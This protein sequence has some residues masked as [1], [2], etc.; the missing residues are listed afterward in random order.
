MRRFL[1]FFLLLPFPLLA[2][3]PAAAPQAKPQTEKPETVAPAP[4]LTLAEA[5]RIGLENNY[6]IRLV[7]QDER[8]AE[9]N[10]TRGNAGQL[11]VVN[12]NLTRNFNRNNINQRFGTTDASGNPTAPRIVN[13]GTS[14]LLNTNVAA[15][16]TIFDGFG[17]FIA[18][19]RLR[20]VA[21]SQEQFT[22]ATAEETV[23]DITDAY[24]TVVRE[25]G[26]IRSFEEALRIGQQRIDLTQ[27]R[28]DVGVGAKVE[29]LTARVDYNA[30]RSALI[31][32]Q[33]AL[34]T[35]KVNLN[36]LL[37]RAPSVDFLPADS[38]VVSR[39]LNRE[40]VTQ[41][42]RQNNPRLQQARIN[43][44]VATY[45]RR[46]VRASHFPQVGLTTGYGFNRNINNAAFAGTQ[47]TTSTNT[48]YGLNYGLVASVP[49][50]DGFNRNRLEQ[51]ARIAEDQSKL[52]LEQTQLQ[53]DAEAE[54]AYAQYQ[55][56]LQLLQ[57]EE[58]N[59]QLARQNVAIALERYRLGLL[60]PLA[61][62]EA[63]RTQ[64][65][66]ENRLL[67]IRFQAKQ[68]ETVLR[69]LSSGL[70]QEQADNGK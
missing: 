69:R 1:S 38:I 33:E 10:V 48:T 13:G 29:V 46:L 58:D 64:L 67:D 21:Q 24:F 41:A 36:N 22:R 66:A 53:L 51:N 39:D 57:L 20:T 5:I 27:A 68:A 17:M 60:T 54:Q 47:L 61:L 31:Q 11:P 56:R 65:D 2:Q 32:Q 4:A 3:Q 28:A 55:N 62:R 26:K 37:G 7:R 35:A 16:W 45:D 70:V 19:D 6:N 34:K 43:T 44:E 63:Q 59:I 9:N 40:T 49:I 8:I 50:F 30:D 42:I 18:Y 15:T 25:A 14:N 52:Q 23:A 12:G